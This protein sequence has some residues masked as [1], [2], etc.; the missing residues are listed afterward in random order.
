MRLFP[1]DDERQIV[2]VLEPG[3]RVGRTGEQLKITRSD[4][5]VEKI[6]LFQVSQVVLHSFSQISTQALH[7][8]CDQN[9]GIHFVI[10]NFA[11]DI[12]F[13]PNQKSEILGV[14]KSWRT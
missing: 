6:P 9:I 2:H 12:N 3:T 5:P 13:N 11:N 14:A 7:T 10:V 1:E 4:Q 8:C